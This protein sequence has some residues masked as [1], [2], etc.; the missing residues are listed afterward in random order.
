MSEV[1]QFDTRC[2]ETTMVPRVGRQHEQILAVPAEDSGRVA[3][4]WRQLAELLDDLVAVYDD[5]LAVS[6]TSAWSQAAAQTLGDVLDGFDVAAAVARSNAEV[7]DD[8][9][10]EITI[11]Q[12]RMSAIWRDMQN[13]NRNRTGPGDASL[14][15]SYSARAA[16]DAW[17]PLTG[18]LATA[19]EQLQIVSDDR[20]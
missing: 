8:L 15:H 9:A 20:S 4:I 14:E 13:E 2:G 16:R 3:G 19:H 1:G 6:P 10:T 11:A 5:R 7:I 17:Y 12:A 18:V